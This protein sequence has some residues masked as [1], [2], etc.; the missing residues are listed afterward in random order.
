MTTTSLA[1]TPA[2]AVSAAD[3]TQLSTPA[4]LALRLGRA[5]FMTAGFVLFAPIIEALGFPPIAALLTAIVLIL[6]P[7]ELGVLWWSGSPS[8]P[9]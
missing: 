3:T 6:V 1:A 7:T 8:T 2:S 9:G 4:L 5:G